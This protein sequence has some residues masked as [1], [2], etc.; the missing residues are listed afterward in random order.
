[1]RNI[2]ST[3]GD[4]DINN[5]V[6]KALNL[7]TETK[8]EAPGFKTEAKGEVVASETEAAYPKTETK[9][10]GYRPMLC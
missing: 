10:Q 5:V 9:A 4:K 7:E 1:V 6:T 2:L 8:T 3:E